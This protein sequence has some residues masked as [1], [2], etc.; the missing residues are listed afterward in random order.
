MKISNA[1]NTVT[2][3]ALAAVVSLVAG[4][5]QA[6]HSSLDDALD[7]ADALV[8]ALDDVAD[9]AADLEAKAKRQG[10]HADAAALDDVENSATV[11]AAKVERQI[12]YAILNGQS[13]SYVKAQLSRL[14]SAFNLLNYDV[15]ALRY[16][17]YQLDNALAEVDYL[18]YDL[19]DI[20]NSSGRDRP[21]RPTRDD[22]R[23]VGGF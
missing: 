20:L 3:I 17:P 4:G 9:I 21:D 5:A 13:I 10:R 8:A 11:L 1:M 12:V 6:R 15:D 22:N 19:A 7:T 18:K 14:S 23:V 2:T 16:I